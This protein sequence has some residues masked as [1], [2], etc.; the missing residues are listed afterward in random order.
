MDLA[1]FSYKTENDALVIK[2]SGHID[3][4]NAKSIETAVF[5]ALAE[6]SAKQVTIDCEGLRYISS[7]GLRV[8]LRLRK[9]AGK[10][11][12]INASPEV[13]DIFEMTGFAEMMN[14]SKAMRVISVDGCRLIG[15]G[16]NGRVYRID[17]ETIVKVYNDT[18][19]LDAIKRET[20]LA[21]RAFVLGIPTA[22]PYDVVRI[23]S[24]GYGSV[25]ELL[26]AASFADLLSSGEKTVKEIAEMSV[27]LLK[28]IHGTVVEPGSIPDMKSVALG[29]ATN[30]EGYLPEDQHKKLI[31]LIAA[32][33]D[34]DHMLHGDF[35]IK[36]IMFQD[37]E[38]LLI[39]MDSLCAGHPVF[40]FAGMF[41]AY[42]AHPELDRP[43]SGSFLGI[44]PLTSAELWNRILH[45]YLD[46][47]G[48]E[49][50]KA[51][52]EKAMIVGYTHLMR[53][54]IRKGGLETEKGRAMVDSCRRHL[55][56]LLPKVDT[57]TF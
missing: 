3:G 39:D 43:V 21:R 56:E 30:L 13:Y 47:A 18:E 20:A 45:L 42:R 37:G 38:S 11:N 12:V 6:S 31:E 57:L 49:T 53:S 26:N 50:V 1:N 44:S 33:P 54:C 10:I 34:S 40:E 25:F 28:T 23:K 52:E 15:S 7:A 17:P 2:L 8:L 14:V 16:A 19:T 4:S 48:E 9:T 46:G 27:D 22:I 24:G 36:N 41:N 35:H 51:V 55:A 32:I 5:S 29:W